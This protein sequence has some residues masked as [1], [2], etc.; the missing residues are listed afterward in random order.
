[1][2]F[3][4]EATTGRIEQVI[5]KLNHEQYKEYNLTIRFTD[6]GTPQLSTKKDVNIVITNV[7]QRPTNILLD[8]EKVY[9]VIIF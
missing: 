2:V 8:N 1:M 6:S 5:N 9:H 4:I 3:K 7:N